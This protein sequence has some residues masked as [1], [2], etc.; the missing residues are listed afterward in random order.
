MVR[1]VSEKRLRRITE[2]IS[3]LPTL[4][5]MVTQMLG[6]VDNPKTSAADLTRLI[7]TDQAMTAKILKL[8][9]SA[10]YGFPRQIATVSLAVVVLGFDTVKDLGLSISVLEGFADGDSDDLFDWERFWEHSIACGVSAKI[11][12]KH[13]RY[14]TVG[15]AFVGGVLHDIGK[16][17]LSQY[18]KE[19]FSEVLHLARKEELF[20]SEAETQALGVTHAEVGK[21]TTFTVKLPIYPEQ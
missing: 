13:L 16:L 5:V 1:G 6:L 15:E 20:I 4:P 14:R 10:F 2:S 12:A 18:L 9:N 17:I 21:G 11:L 8:A 7:S 19:A 3:G